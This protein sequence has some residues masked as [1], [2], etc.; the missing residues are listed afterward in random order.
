MS[1]YVYHMDECAFALPS[2]FVDNTLHNFE[3][4]GPEGRRALMVQRQKPERDEDFA[5]LVARITQAY[6][7]VFASYVE[8]DGD[9]VD[10]GAPAVS[11]RFR[12]RHTT[13]V[14]YHHQVFIDVGDT[15]LAVTAS[16]KA[17]ARDDID[18]ILATALRG[19][20]LRERS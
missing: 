7:Q 11:K 9:T 19:F 14:F 13:G 10:V 15:V 2:D 5:T 16:G 1:E 20:Q 4:V 12:W 8:E 3:W 17:S 18:G 6:P